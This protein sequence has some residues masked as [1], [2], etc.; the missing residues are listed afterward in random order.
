MTA[1][2]LRMRLEAIEK[3]RRASRVVVF[4][5]HHLVQPADGRPY[6]KTGESVA[7]CLA[8]YHITRGSR[9]CI[10]LNLMGTDSVG[11]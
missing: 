7:D 4:I 9:L 3:R 8:R 2:T 10:F 1:S 5:N 11:P 6:R